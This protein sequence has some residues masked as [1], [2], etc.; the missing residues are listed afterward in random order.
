MHVAVD[1]SHVPL[2]QSPGPA[3]GM[4]VC[5]QQRFPADVTTLGAHTAPVPAWQQSPSLVH[6]HVAALRQRL[7]SDATQLAPDIVQVPPE[8]SPPQ[9]S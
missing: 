1:P 2:Q 8:Q 7:P 4:P 3:H 5:R 6:A 9:Q